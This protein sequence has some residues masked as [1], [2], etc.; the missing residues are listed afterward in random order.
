MATAAPEDSNRTSGAVVDVVTGPPG[1]GK[2]TVARAL[3]QQ[4][5]RC[6]LIDGDSY[7]QSIRTG[8]IPPWEPESNEQNV[9]VVRAI[10][11]SASAFAHGGFEVVIEGII[12]PW[13]LPTLRAALGD[14]DLRYVVIR[15]T[16]DVAMQRATER[17]EPW[18]IDP[19]PITRMYEQFAALGAYESFVVDTSALSV[20]ESIAA[21]DRI[22]LSSSR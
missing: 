3:V 5:E 11:A 1:A 19:A 2:T 4:R 13:M 15:P 20:D 9:T 6:V 12:G 14:V 7:F 18:L 8:W 16:A 22:L 21:A 10:G 17:G